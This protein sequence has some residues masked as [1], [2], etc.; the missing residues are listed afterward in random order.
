MQLGPFEIDAWTIVFAVFTL[1]FVGWT[2]RYAISLRRELL[3]RTGRMEGKV[4]EISDA[5]QQIE[6][7]IEEAF[8]DLD[9]KLDVLQ[10]ERKIE[11]L[12][13]KREETLR[14]I[15]GDDE[16]EAEE[17]KGSQK[18]QVSIEYIS[19]FALLL[20]PLLIAVLYAYSGISGSSG[21]EADVSL[22]RLADSA[23][24]LYA[25]GPGASSEVDIYLPG[26]IDANTSFIGNGTGGSGNYLSL[27][28]SGANSFRIVRATVNGSWP[29]VGG[30]V[31]SG[32]SVMNLTVNGSGVV[33]ISQYK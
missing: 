3:E 7:D 9:N 11:E 22:E 20:V 23:E 1:A 17:K 28:I 27:N 2:V 25:Q 16:E 4:K 12:E 31:E 14:L 15:R 8:S 10:L 32:F 21:Y 5:T 30:K 18:G 24:K 29:V 19:I 6:T 13:T 26:S 33:L